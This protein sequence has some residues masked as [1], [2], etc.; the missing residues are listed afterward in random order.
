MSQDIDR[1]QIGEELEAARRAREDGNEGM[2]R[3][4]ARRAAGWAIGIHFKKEVPAEQRVNAYGLLRWYSRQP[5]VPEDLRLAADRLTTR[6]SEDHTLP[7]DQDPLVDAR[8][9][10]EAL[11]D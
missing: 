6:I 7:H 11:L 5:S 4:C 2:A 10:V 8:L 1:G 9:L 3:V